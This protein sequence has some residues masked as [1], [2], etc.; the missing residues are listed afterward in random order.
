MQHADAQGLGA[1][2]FMAWVFTYAVMVVLVWFMYYM[3]FAML[4]Y[5]YRFL[6]CVRLSPS[7]CITACKACLTLYMRARPSAYMITPCHGSAKV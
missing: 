5:P 6:R 4:L 1:E 2:K 3:V 7:V